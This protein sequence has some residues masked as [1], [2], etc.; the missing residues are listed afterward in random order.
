MSMNFKQNIIQYVID[1]VTLCGEKWYNWK[2]SKKVPGKDKWETL[3]VIP[4]IPYVGVNNRQPILH[5]Y[6][7]MV[8]WYS[9]D[10]TNINFEIGYTINPLLNCNKVFRVQ[11]EIFLSFSFV[12]RTMENII[13][14][15]KD[16]KKCIEC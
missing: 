16:S 5:M 9:T 10:E 14:C 7:R 8:H 13:D 4:L 2:K 15:L 12:S 11:V 1:I 6:K 3:A